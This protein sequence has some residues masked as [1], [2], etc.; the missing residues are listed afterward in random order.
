MKLSIT[1]SKKN[2]I[3][4]PLLVA[5]FWLLLW[6]VVYMAVN[7][8][9]LVVSPFT[10]IKYLFERAQ[11]WIF[12]KTIAYSI[13]RILIGYLMGVVAGVLLAV[14]TFRSRIADHIL[15]PVLTIIKTAPV[16]SFIML[17]IV[18]I[19]R[20][21]LPK[22]ISFLMVLPFVW[23]NVRQGI[24]NV[25]KK[26]LDYARAYRFT[27]IKKL[28]YI[29]I[30]SIMPYF[31]AAALTGV[32]LTWKAGVA[33]EVLNQPDFAIGRQLYN[34]KMYLETAELF[35]WTAVIILL[36]MLIEKLLTKALKGLM[37][38]YRLTGRG[39]HD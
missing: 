8:E 29:Y 19:P 16:V 36:S 17:A 20:N 33:A 31:T 6:Q 13:G 38:K 11:H 39:K 4:I 7:Q 24:E 5:A 34:A 25:D 2:K 12:W 30:P 3:V 18:W 10:V 1:K 9:I 21:D 32:G 35:A 27:R 14:I 26:Y 37:Q 22:F 28:R 15:R 23:A